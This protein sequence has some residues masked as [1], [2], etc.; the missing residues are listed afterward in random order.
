MQTTVNTMKQASHYLLLCILISVSLTACHD[1]IEDFGDTTTTQITQVDVQELTQSDVAGYIYDEA[2]SA[3]ADVEVNVLGATT[4]TNDYGV[5]TFRNIDLDKNGTYVTATKS[6]YILG[7]DRIYPKDADVN[8]SYIKMMQ[9]SS[10]DHKA[11]CSGAVS[12]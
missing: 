12:C 11:T 1:D 3:M 4:R 6:G 10:N 2:G 5:F 8:Y 7:S 9:L